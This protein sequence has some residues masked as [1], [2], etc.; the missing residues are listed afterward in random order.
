MAADIGVKV[1][2]EGYSKFKTEIQDITQQQK[3]LKSEMNAVTSAWNKNTS[4][5]KKNAETKRIL[6]EQI[7]AQ[8]QKVQELQKVLTEVEKKYGEN[9]RE[10]N[11]WREKLNNA[12][13]DLNKM[14]AELK[15][16]PSGIDLFGQRIQEAGGK[17]TAFGE[18]LKGV[19]EGLT[20]AVTVPLAAVG[21][22]S[23]AAFTEYDKG[24]DTIIAKTGATGDAL[25]EMQGIM[26]GLATSIP[27][28][29][30]TAGA[31]VGEVNTRFGLMG[32]ELQN[33]SSAFLQFAQLNGTDVSGS[34]DKVQAS[35]TAF[36]MTSAEATTALDI[37]NKAGQD[38]GISV[39]KLSSDLMSNS[40]ILKEMGF[41]YNEAAGFIANLNKNGIDSSTVMAG[42]KKA[43]QN[44]T[45]EGKPL[46][47]ALKE[48]EAELKTAN[49][50]TE[51]MQKAT[52]LFGAKAA[53]QLVAALQEGRISLDEAANAVQNYGDSVS[54]TFEATLSPTD[55][56]KTTLN[57][58]KIVG[59]ELGSTLLEMAVPAL[60]KLSEIVTAA[61]TAWDGLTPAQQETIVKMGLIAA[62]IG[63]VVTII[64]GLITGIGGLITTFGTL[65]PI[66]ASGA[67]AFGAVV[68]AAAPFIAIGAAVVAAGVL[69]YKNWDT[70]KEKAGELAQTVSQKFDEIKQSATEKWEAVKQKTSETW[71]IVKQKVAEAGKVMLA[72]VNTS[73]SNIQAAYVEKGGGISGAAAAIMTA[74]EEAFKTGYDVLNSL[75][76][77][78]FG[79]I[80]N[81][82]NEKT[83]G[84]L[85][86]AKEVWEGIKQAVQ[87]GVDK[88]KALMNFEWK[89]PHLDL[90]HFHISGSFSLNPPSV[91]SFSVDWYS[92][93][94]QNGMILNSPTIFGMQNGQL[95]GAG[96]AG[97][98]VVV[99]A[100]SLSRMIQNAVNTT[101]NTGGNTIN[102]YGAP[103]QDVTELAHEVA[104]IINGEVQM[105][106]AVWA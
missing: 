61:K 59:A 69:I 22:A 14:N 39:D 8:E 10:A 83:G 49:S 70:I 89:L 3:T 57:E 88:I 62:A 30:E 28:D 27:T 4:A 34:I 7:K 33:V 2:V 25:K 29:F 13:A 96:E 68:A 72:D 101:Y 50:N 102:V 86:K 41:S 23:V 20:K 74:V 106:G 85:D 38:T 18:G 92:K 55:K 76:D 5:E 80:V 19:G 87:D 78:K 40:T 58:V 6:N 31:A 36:G 66:I 42:M 35:M 103:G 16:L 90:P 51:A 48:L 47:Q 24:A 45:K 79:E 93:A 82:F 26:E 100:G 21:A 15:S 52:E 99:G 17:V 44:A 97:A 43:M 11:S 60:Q 12:T 91:P 64:G 105:R 104:D 37:L 81:T 84:M 63:P 54:N 98:E 75:T 46:K 56:M 32:D 1:A 71:D 65:I 9:S 94:M 53:P 77:G 95:L 67:A 73:L